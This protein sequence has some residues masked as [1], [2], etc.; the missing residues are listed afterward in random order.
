[1]LALVIL[2]A[3]IPKSG[4]QLLGKT[5]DTPDF[6]RFSWFSM[7]FGAGVGIG[8][9][10]YATA[11]PIF[12]FTEN[13][14]TIMGLV[15]G[16]S[17]ENVRHAYKWA[18]LH[19]ALTPWALYAIVGISLAYFGYN[20]DLPLTIRAPLQPLFGKKLS[21]AFGHAID[22]AAILATVLGV[23]VTIGYG[24][25]QFTSGLFNISPMDW[26]MDVNGKPSLSAQ[27]FAL[28]IVVGLSTISALSGIN[29][30]IKWLSNTN[31]GLSIFLLLF[32][33]VFGALGFAIKAFGLTIWDYIVSLPTMSLTHWQNSTDETAKKLFDWQAAWTIFYWAWWIAFAPFVGSFL[34]KVSR[35]RS[36][37]EYVLGAVIV[38]SLTCLTWFTLVGGTAI[39]LELSG[40]AKGAILNADTSSQLFETINLMLSP[41]LAAAMSAVIIALL[42]TY[43][44]TSV[45]SAIL[46]IT[47]IAA[48]GKQ[49]RRNSKHII[50]WGVLF[51]AVIASLLAAGGLD[52]IRSAMIIG[53]LPF[54]MIMLLT[55]ISL[56]KCL[57]FSNQD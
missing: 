47:T 6:S 28:V 39:D 38:P 20:R 22:I 48:A 11:E 46:V 1:M 7:M 57:F 49:H 35:G 42:L 10:T 50:I 56:I 4:K 19:W 55:S 24:V 5:D 52:A 30:G 9:L 31:M 8:M 37:R 43:L 54:S 23:S 40:L 41:E 51:V 25:S 18:A 29:K 26:L 15:A 36:I 13:P 14:E 27:V 17:A 21:G 16:Q 3:V 53:A 34:A 45:D 33:T 32:F 12:H 2:L 44:V